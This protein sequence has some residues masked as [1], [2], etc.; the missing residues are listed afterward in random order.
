MEATMADSD[1]TTANQSATDPSETVPKGTPESYFTPT[2]LAE[3]EFEIGLVLGG[4]VSVGSYTAGVLD[5]LIEALDAWETAKHED[6]AN[7][8]NHRVRL[9]II[10]GTSGGGISAVLTARALHYRFAPAASGTPAA[11][12]A[13]NP[14]YD[15]WVKQPSLEKMLHSDDLEGDPSP[16][17]NSLL[18]GNV[19][20]AIAN[21]G[22]NYPAP[23]Q[24]AVVE[25]GKPVASNAEMGEPTGH[26][27][28]HDAE[29]AVR[30]A[31]PGERPYI[32]NPLPVIVTHSNVT[33]VPYEQRFEG[34]VRSEFYTNHADYVRVY[35]DYPGPKTAGQ[36]DLISDAVGVLEP[37]GRAP[38]GPL[39]N[40][41]TKP[42]NL[43]ILGWSDLV[44]FVLGTSAFPVGLP[45][46]TIS[47]SALHY[48]YRFVW[49][50]ADGSYQWIRPVWSRFISPAQADSYNFP[51]LDGGC[52]NN[53]PITLA[54]QSLEGLRPLYG[55]TAAS[56]EA[57]TARRAIVLVDPL[58]E[59]PP[60]SQ[61]DQSLALLSIAQPAASMFV[62]SNRFATADMA[63]F[64]HPAM[65]TR[66]LVAPRRTDVLNPL[67]PPT[68][69][70]DALCGT[71]LGA[72]LGF[73]SEAYRDHDFMLGRYNCQAFLA[74]TLTLAKEH[75]VFG[76]VPPGLP[77]GDLP[78]P[79]AGQLPLIPLCGSAKEVF[80]QPEWPIDAFNP[81]QLK[82]LLRKR[83]R[84]VLYSSEGLL[85][86][87]PLERIVFAIGNIWIAHKLTTQFLKQI[88]LACINKHLLSGAAAPRLA[89]KSR[90]K[91]ITEGNQASPPGTPP[92][93]QH[94]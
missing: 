20:T 13:C 6:P 32:H 90:A 33:G 48:V 3:N 24:L 22:V 79:D 80:D 59:T 17:L 70:G 28:E 78:Q 8:P 58:C 75:P 84:K 81:I 50:T 18:N 93:E 45:A 2:D 10:T 71:G 53:E 89:S 94:S 72:F 29:L 16:A 34:D 67:K 12:L 27:N 66:F 61:P 39:A 14:F 63:D 36:P 5:F 15:I 7:T 26:A 86:R 31:K 77:P 74:K 30:D 44:P 19:L 23:D 25:N 35:F 42:A 76:G 52:T 60:Q 65:Y 54:R 62:S 43:S 21:R 68:V 37:S 83:I 88:T 49:S 38:G 46:R 9:R 85:Q 64:I 56:T 69:G 82:K 91:A 47:R 51:S 73:V 92:V 41:A 4:T 40:P 11:I 57:A 87:N 55:A 1:Q